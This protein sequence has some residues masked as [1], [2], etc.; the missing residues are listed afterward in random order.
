[1]ESEAV[2]EAVLY[3]YKAVPFN[4]HVLSGDEAVQ[5]EPWEFHTISGGYWIFKAEN[6]GMAIPA[7]REMTEEMNTIHE[8]RLR[9]TSELEDKS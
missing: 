1:M 3:R 5:S 4:D 7:N 8:A 6:K 9:A 2:R